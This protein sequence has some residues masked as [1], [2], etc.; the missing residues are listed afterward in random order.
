MLAKLTISP[1]L[2]VSV[3]VLVYTLSPLNE[4]TGALFKVIVPASTD[5]T[6]E[7]IK[8]KMIKKSKFYFCNSLSYYPSRQ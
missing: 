3:F 5:K 6:N 2:D 4:L 8:T 7:N 1:T